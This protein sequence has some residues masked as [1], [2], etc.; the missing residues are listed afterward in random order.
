MS[1]SPFL[2]PAAPVDTWPQI[3][4]YFEALAKRNLDS[5]ANL[6]AF[7][8]DWSELSAAVSEARSRRYTAMT[9]D[10]ENAAVEREYL[11][12]AEEVDPKVS[13]AV[14]K[15]RE[16]FLASPARK[17]L[18]NERYRVLDRKLQ[19]ERDLFRKENIPLF[20]EEVK[21]SQ[22]Y[23][24]LCGAMTVQWHG[25]ES[26]LQRMGGRISTAPRGEREEIWK[27]VWERRNADRARADEIFDQLLGLRAEIGRNAGFTDYQDYVF[28]AYERFDYTPAHCAAFHAAIERCVVPLARKM[29]KRH[30]E[31]LGVAELRPWDIGTGRL[32]EILVEAKTSPAPR[33]FKDEAEFTRKGARVLERVSPVLSER[34]L[35]MQ[36]R[37]EFDLMNRK[38]KAPGAY[39][40]TFER[41]RR[42]FLFMNATGVG[43]D[44]QTLFHEYGHAFHALETTA[45]PLTD[46]R[47]VGMEFSEVASMTMELFTLDELSEY[48]TPEQHRIARRRAL[49]HVALFL[50]YMAQVDLFQSWIYKNPKH[51][52]AER[53]AEWVRLEARFG[54]AIDWRGCEHL[55][56]IFWHQQ[57][58]IFGAPFYYVEYGI[59]QLGALQLWAKYKK[60]PAGA[61]A[62]Y[63]RGLSL[64]GSKT[65]PELFEAAEI[66]FDF[67]EK[68]VRPLFEM[69]EAEWAEK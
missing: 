15:L 24:K 10:T 62:A 58:H 27:L 49:E 39:V 54:A 63:R 37:G 6:E 23:Q 67:S 47:S 64:G 28:R 7:L 43:D 18:P 36:K 2:D 34:F 66:E 19:N 51:T 41:V 50:P 65:L 38:G 48:Y 32:F 14:Q 31:E 20:V 25:E 69:V 11:R 3:E 52:P 9:C 5:P 33:P 1:K 53:G 44:V 26:T 21:F 30:Q 68:T 60:D 29:M 59:A 8:L 22:R 55:R 35:E 12:F 16:R 46:Y 45:E 61:V 56:E 13:E 4:P 42:P 40:T 17:L 57:L